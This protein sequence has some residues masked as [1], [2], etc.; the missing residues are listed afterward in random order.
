MKVLI[1]LVKDYKRC[2]VVLCRDWVIIEFFYGENKILVK[3]VK[4]EERMRNFEGG[5]CKE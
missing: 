4:R 5:E 2:F 1:R 3:W